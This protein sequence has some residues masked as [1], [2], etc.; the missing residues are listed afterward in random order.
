MRHGGFLAGSRGNYTV[1]RFGPDSAQESKYFPLLAYITTRAH[2]APICY[3]DAN[4]PT[5]AAHS[6]PIC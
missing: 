5:L 4:C 3:R 6:A 2:S 1:V